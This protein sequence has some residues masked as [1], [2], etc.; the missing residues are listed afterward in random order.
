MPIL[1]VG[2]LRPPKVMNLPEVMWMAR[3]RA[4]SSGYQASAFSH[5]PASW[6]LE[7]VQLGVGGMDI[8][9]A[10]GTS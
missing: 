3:G 4:R 1:L 9:G 8:L 2:R 10:Y 7:R 5:F 6:D